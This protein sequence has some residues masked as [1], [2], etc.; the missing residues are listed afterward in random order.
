[1]PCNDIKELARYGAGELDG[2]AVAR[3]VSSLSTSSLRSL[4]VYAL[5]DDDDDDDDDDGGGERVR[6]AALF[7]DAR[8]VPPLAWALTLRFDDLVDDAN[9]AND[10]ASALVQRVLTALRRHAF[11][12]SADDGAAR[13]AL[14]ERRDRFLDQLA[15]EAIE[16][17][18]GLPAL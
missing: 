8:L 15:R 4:L 11:V 6:F 1:M 16:A 5:A 12:D 10:N 3:V 7:N 9:D 13:R 18:F 2:A 17:T 14:L